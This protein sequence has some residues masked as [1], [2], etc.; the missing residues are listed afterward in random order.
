MQ[1]KKRNIN[2]LRILSVNYIIQQLTQEILANII[3][4][5]ANKEMLQTVTTLRSYFPEFLPNLNYLK[6]HLESLHNNFRL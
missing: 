5:S 2:I 6:T 1:I 4:L 3:A